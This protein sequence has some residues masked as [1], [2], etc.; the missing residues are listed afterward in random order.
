[1]HYNKQAHLMHINVKN[2]TSLT[3]N[4]K[5]LLYL[6]ISTF[7]VLKLTLMLTFLQPAGSPP[8][9]IVEVSVCGK[10]VVGASQTSKLSG[11]A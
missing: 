8:S 10:L 1:M 9:G 6:Y 11:T 4:T 3:A 5:V 2:S 7:F